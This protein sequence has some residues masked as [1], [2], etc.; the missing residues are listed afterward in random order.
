MLDIALRHRFPQFALDVAFA[1]PPGLT[2]LFGASGAG[3]STIIAAIAGLLRPDEGRI[4]LGSETLFDSAAGI[5]LPPRKRGAGCIFQDERLFPHMS[6]RANLRYGTGGRAAP[7]EPQVVDMLGIGPLLARRPGSLSGG[8]KARVGIGRALLSGAR[9]ILADEPLAA[10]DA[11]RR[12]EILPYF[13]RLR[14]E[15]DIPVLY[16]CHAAREAARLATSVVAL[17]EGRVLRQGP[18][19]EILADPLIHPAGLREVGAVVTARLVRHHADGLSEMDACGATLW[20]PR[21]AHDEGAML[22]IRIAAQDVILALHPPKDTSALNCLSGT[23]LAIH[24]EQGPGAFVTLDTA[25]GPIVSRI[26]MRSLRALGLRAG[27]PA[28]AI[29]KSLSVAP[30]DVGG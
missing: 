22:R 18:P 25:A 8:E 19:A 10:L 3:K 26:T 24:E 7:Q 20:L 15:T 5:C 21:P 29:V 2:V 14:D 13:E 16:V 28:H 6:V 11:P 30:G 9:M 23:I 27:S 4:T 1:A 12:E 17:G